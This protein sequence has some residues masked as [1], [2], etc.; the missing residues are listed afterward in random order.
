MTTSVSIKVMFIEI[1]P[2]YIFQSF[3]HH[4]VLRNVSLITTKLITME[5]LLLILPCKSINSTHR[6]IQAIMFKCI[7][8]VVIT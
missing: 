4:H 5:P 8:I 7:E 3:D 6:Y 1:L 2:R